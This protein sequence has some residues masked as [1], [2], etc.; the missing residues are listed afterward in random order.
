MTIEEKFSRLGVDNAPGQESLQ[1][2]LPLI[3]SS[4]GTSAASRIS[5]IPSWIP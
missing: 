1:A 4:Y 2:D 3:I 5:G